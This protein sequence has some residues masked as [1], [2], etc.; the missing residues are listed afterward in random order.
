MIAEIIIAVCSVLTLIISIT[1]VL[2]KQFG[3]IEKRF[4]KI[5]KKFDNFTLDLKEIQKDLRNLDVRMSRLE[6][7]FTE[8]GNWASKE[9]KVGE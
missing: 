3:K 2:G 9:K 1:K 7:G 8:R 6:G 4:D 5:D